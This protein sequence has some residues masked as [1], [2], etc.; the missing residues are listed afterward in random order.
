MAFLKIDKLLFIPRAVLG[1]LVTLLVT[2]VAW[3]RKFVR[4]RWVTLLIIAGVGVA[5]YA[6]PLAAIAIEAGLRRFPLFTWQM[7]AGIT[8]V[9]FFLLS[10]AAVI[11]VGFRFLASILAI[12]LQ[13]AREFQSA[14]KVFKNY[15][16]EN[17]K[18]NTE[19]AAIPVDEEIQ[20]QMEDIRKLKERGLVKDEEIEDLIRE[21][22]SG[23]GDGLPSI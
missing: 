8:A 5:A 7:I 9:S 12:E 13:V 1:L 16:Q 11:Y 15:F 14:N 23:G 18:Q 10:L 6:L 3:T 17:K 4:K 20:A 21:A 2:P 22:Y 19:G